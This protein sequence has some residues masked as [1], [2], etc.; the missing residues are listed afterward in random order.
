M[1]PVESTYFIKEG[2]VHNLSANSFDHSAQGEYW[3]QQRVQTA[4]RYQYHVYAYARRIAIQRRFKSLLDIGCGPAIKVNEL[5][6]PVMQEITLADQPNCRDLVQSIV[7]SA[8]FHSADLETDF[9]LQRQF[10]LIV[11][12]DVLEHLRNPLPCLQVALRH[13]R[14][15]GV[16]IFST[17]DR[18]ILR[19]P[20]CLQSPHPN[21]VREWSMKEFAQLLNYEGFEVVEHTLVPQARLPMWEDYLRYPLQFFVRTAKWSGCQLAVCRSKATKG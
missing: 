20:Q 5:L 15:G 21:H 3:T 7:P 11:C 18:D 12:A 17:P 9:D 8:R 2:Y 10:D 1:K 13:L 4:T 6:V 14:P 16:A 19:G